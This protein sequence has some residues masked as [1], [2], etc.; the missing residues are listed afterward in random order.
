VNLHENILPT[1]Q[2]S[3]LILK[4]SESHMVEQVSLRKL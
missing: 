3:D 2:R 4:K 1:R